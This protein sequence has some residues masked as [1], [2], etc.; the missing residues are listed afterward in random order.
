M[1]VMLMAL[2]VP[3][4]SYGKGKKGSRDASHTEDEMKALS[5]AWDA[6]RKG[7]S[8]AGRKNLSVSDIFSMG[9]ES[10]KDNKEASDGE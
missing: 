9:E 4:V 3:V 10:K 8:F 6:R 2:D 1:Q 5:D 7:F